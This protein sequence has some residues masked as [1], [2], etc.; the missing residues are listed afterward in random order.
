VFE[1]TAFREREQPNVV[2]SRFHS[3]NLFGIFSIGGWHDESTRLALNQPS[4][5]TIKK[6]ETDFL[7]AIG[8]LQDYA[9]CEK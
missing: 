4:W 8:L 1:L 5:I 9:I 7:N 6:L 2:S 3:V